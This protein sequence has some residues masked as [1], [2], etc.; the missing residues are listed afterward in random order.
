MLQYK[1]RSEWRKQL[2]KH[3]QI[4][5]LATTSEDISNHKSTAADAEVVDEDI[6]PA[7]K[8]AQE[9]LKKEIDQIAK[10]ENESSMAA[11]LIK[12]IKAE[13]KM[14]HRQLKLDPW[15]ASRTPNAKAEPPV[16]TRFD[17]PVNACKVY[18]YAKIKL[19]KNLIF[20]NIC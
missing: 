20:K 8:L 9:K 14:A 10:L 4:S 17:S 15:K 18:V 7:E 13:Q 2:E 6:E 1:P 5:G 11:D 16:R 19:K 12:E 3:K